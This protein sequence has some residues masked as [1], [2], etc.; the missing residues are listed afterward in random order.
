MT[1]DI[2]R[3]QRFKIQDQFDPAREIAVRIRVDGPRVYDSCCFGLDA[4]GKIK[5]EPFTVFYNQKS[6]PGGE[7]SMEGSG[8]DTTYK[9]ELQRL[10]DDIQ[11]LALTISIDGQGVLRDC[12][13][14][15]VEISQGGES[16]RL[17]LSG[18]D[19]AEEKALI[20]VEIYRKD[21]WRL[22]AVASGFNGGL[23][24]LL[25]HFGG[26]EA[27]TGPPPPPP[28]PSRITLEKRGDG[29][30][31]D[32]TKKTASTAFHINLNWS[33]PGWGAA[34]DLDLGCM[35]QMVS[36]E[37][38]VVQALGNTMGSATAP[39]YIYL[40]QDDR[41][42]ASAEGENLHILRPSAM[43]RV[44]IYSFIYEGS[45]TFKDVDARILVKE[46][47]GS[48]TLIRLDA[49]PRNSTHCAACLLRNQGGSLRITKEDLYFNSHKEIDRHFGF[50]FNWVPGRK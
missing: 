18:A 34:A 7:I 40:D 49:S 38:G 5:R 47:D 12:R 23:P 6:S 21:V 22:A 31:V 37:K 30:M 50:G 32:L 9:I 13:S 44:L 43:S 16:A 39:P 42:G 17:A 45:K 19:L 27:L 46:P 10:P 11:K 26:E 15:A 3:G 29:R 24:A 14:V 4:S 1:R 25:A 41:T 8:A 20:A 2:Q 36:G 48:E 33:A 35:W 28:G